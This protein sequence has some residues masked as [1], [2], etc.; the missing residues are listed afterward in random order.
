MNEEKSDQIKIND[1][2]NNT[3][4]RCTF[5]RGVCAR[6]EGLNVCVYVLYLFFCFGEK[7]FLGMVAPSHALW[8]VDAPAKDQGWVP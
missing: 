8:T 3:V 2:C 1:F 6:V 5:C 7:E 4:V